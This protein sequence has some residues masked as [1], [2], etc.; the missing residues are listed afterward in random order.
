M[1]CHLAHNNKSSETLYTDF[2]VWCAGLW[3]LCL[4]PVLLLKNIEIYFTVDDCMIN[5]KFVE[6]NFL[7]RCGLP[8]LQ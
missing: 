8:V 6:G 7:K 1:K 4:V 3:I 2:L 5:T